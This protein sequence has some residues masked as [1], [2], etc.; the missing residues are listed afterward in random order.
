MESQLENEI[1]GIEV[2]YK[3]WEVA[4]ARE[5]SM[6]AVLLPVEYM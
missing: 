4:A 5:L 2:T 3:Y 1:K 6:R